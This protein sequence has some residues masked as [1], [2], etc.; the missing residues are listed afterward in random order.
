MPA[1][2]EATRTKREGSGPTEGTRRTKAHAPHTRTS[3][4]TLKS[5]HAYTHTPTHL[6][7]HA[8]TYA[9]THARAHALLDQAD[10]IKVHAAQN[11]LT[12]IRAFDQY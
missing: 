4:H 6:R 12:I 5:T 1:D 11:V 10:R 8:H 9:R 2:S 7:T 3:A